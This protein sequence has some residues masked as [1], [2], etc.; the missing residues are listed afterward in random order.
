MACQALLLRRSGFSPTM[1]ALVHHTQA[2]I[3]T[4]HL[5]KL[6]QLLKSQT[7]K[8]PKCLLAAQSHCI[9]GSK[10]MHCTCQKETEACA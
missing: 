9:T 5:K 4:H 10:E 7:I 6:G 3:S 8:Q 1:L 2:S